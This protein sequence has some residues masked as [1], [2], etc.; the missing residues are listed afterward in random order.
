[1]I[2]A[3]L[4]DLDGTLLDRDETFRRFLYS[5]ATRF[6]HLVS[7]SQVDAYVQQAM[8]IDR[9]GCELRRAVFDQLASRLG[10]DTAAGAEL[11]KDFEDRFPEECVPFPGAAAVV[12][13]L[14]DQGLMTGLI[15]NGWEGVQRR[16]VAKLPFL[17]RFEVAL[18]SGEEGVR[19][20]DPEIFQRALERLELK[21]REAVFVGDNPETD[22]AGCRTVGMWAVW[23]ETAYMVA[24]TEVDGVIGEL[25]EL[26]PLVEELQEKAGTSVG[27]NAV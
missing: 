25:H 9:H 10:F 6:S 22:I 12:D 3:V 21:P 8:A 18:V 16:K 15:T 20:P 24:P 5:Q 2:K 11:H 27:G 1:M 26:L 4:F 14:I 7:A 17:S 13:N 23:K 19:K